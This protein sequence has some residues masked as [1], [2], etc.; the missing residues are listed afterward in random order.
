[1]DTVKVEKV[2]TGIFATAVKGCSS[3]FE[4]KCCV[5]YIQEFDFYNQPCFVSTITKG[6][7]YGIVVAAS[8]VKLPQVFK[9]LG[10]KSG[11]GITVLGV[12]L[13]LLAITFNCCYS[14]RR[15][16][17]FSAWGEAI[18]LAI[19]TVIIAILVLWYDNKK[20][21]A[22]T[23]GTVYSA[24]VYTL[25]NKA[26]VSDNLLW[27][28]QST[29]LYLSVSGK[30]TQAFKNY[31]AQ[32]TGQLSAVTAVA[33]LTGSIIRILTTIQETGDMLTAITF[34]ASA[35]ANAVVVFQVFYYWALTQK[36]ISKIE[37]KKDK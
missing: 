3:L 14:F 17:P 30:L 24:L 36:F 8:L 4:P 37:G 13:E 27:Y 9:I 5:K 35:S 16:F 21:Q 18:F 12:L 25:L 6:V 7:G 22:I 34:A 2:A 19:E 29:V 10:N 11:T 32:H 31:K 28:F 1:M 23:L 20:K 33:I 15:N 26:L